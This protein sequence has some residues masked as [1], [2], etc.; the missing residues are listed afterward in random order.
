MQSKKMI[1]MWV[2]SIGRDF[3]ILQGFKQRRLFTPPTSRNIP[4][5]YCLTNIPQTTPRGLEM[6][7][8]HRQG[9]INLDVLQN[10][11]KIKTCCYDRHEEENAETPETKRKENASARLSSWRLSWRHICFWNKSSRKPFAVSFMMCKL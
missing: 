4:H 6:R 2:H 9:M 1:I 3:C 5:P 7:E 8:F 11:L 10:F